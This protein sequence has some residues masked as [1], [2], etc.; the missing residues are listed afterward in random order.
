RRSKPSRAVERNRFRASGS[1]QFALGRARVSRVD[2]G[3]LAVMNF[4]K[5]CF[6]ETPKPTRKTHALPRLLQPRFTA[7]TIRAASP[8]AVLTPVCD[9]HSAWRRVPAASA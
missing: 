8:P 1:V 6:S 9:T 3:V 5:A 2:D 7:K 4:L